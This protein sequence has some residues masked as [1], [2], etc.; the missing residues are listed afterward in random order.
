MELC[1]EKKNKKKHVLPT[2]SL[3]LAIFQTSLSLP[4]KTA[5]RDKSSDFLDKQVSETR[6][7]CGTSV[8]TCFPT[9][10]THLSASALFS[11]SL[12]GEARQ[13]IPLK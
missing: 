1:T 2:L 11:E 8:R 6:R 9:A 12:R 4:K 7:Y 10:H 5:P 13:R 3:D